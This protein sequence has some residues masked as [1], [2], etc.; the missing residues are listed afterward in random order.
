M[1]TSYMQ[2]YTQ[3]NAIVNKSMQFVPYYQS[4]QLFNNKTI[5]IIV[6]FLNINIAD[7]HKVQHKKT[8][9]IILIFSIVFTYFLSNFAGNSK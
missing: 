2:L 9:I 8:F 1:S 7:D 5:V 4:N 6:C 3:K